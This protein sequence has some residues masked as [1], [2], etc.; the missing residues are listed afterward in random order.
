MS[1]LTPVQK[2]MLK[3]LASP[4]HMAAFVTVGADSGNEASVFSEWEELLPLSDGTVQYREQPLM[5]ES[6]LQAAYTRGVRLDG[7]P[8]ILQRDVV[9]DRPE[10][11]SSIHAVVGAGLG[12]MGLLAWRDVVHGDKNNDAQVALLQESW[13][14]NWREYLGNEMDFSQEKVSE[15]LE[16]VLDSAEDAFLAIPVTQRHG[17]PKSLS[18]GNQGT[19]PARQR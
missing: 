13:V 18:P 16:A 6:F 5:L 11:E 8:G 10:Y 12:A 14:E 7:K 19:K 2:A 4:V 1:A 15:I 9:I 17:D 3:T